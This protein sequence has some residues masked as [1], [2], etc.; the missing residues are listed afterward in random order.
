MSKIGEQISA[1]LQRFEEDYTKF[2]NGNKAASTRARKALMEI[3]NLA[4]EGRKELTA[5][6]APKKES[7][8]NGGPEEPTKSPI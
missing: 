7:D 6:R 5:A 3:K 8:G 1:A 4:S 2:E